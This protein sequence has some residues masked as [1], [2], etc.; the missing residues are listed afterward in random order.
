M[1]SSVAWLAELP[2]PL[3]SVAAHRGFKSAVPFLLPLG[4]GDAGPAPADCLLVP[5][6]DRVDVVL[7]LGNQC[8]PCLM[9]F[10]GL[11]HSAA[12]ILKLP[13]GS[14]TLFPGREWISLSLIPSGKG[15]GEP[16]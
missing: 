2:L 11:E 13:R 16:S 14:D 1:Q 12:Y 6:S 4:V 7:F 10:P 8:W 15:E 5:P 9:D 3:T